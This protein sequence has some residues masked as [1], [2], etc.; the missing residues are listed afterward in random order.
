LPKI[1]NLGNHNLRPTT[2]CSD[3]S[4]VQADLRER[5]D[6]HCG[7]RELDPCQEVGRKKKW[8]QQANCDPM[9]SGSI[10]N[11]MT[12]PA[13]RKYIHR[14]TNALRGCDQGV[15]DLFKNVVVLDEDGK[16]WPVPIMWGTQEKAAAYVVQNQARKD[17]TLVVNRPILPL[18]AIHSTD[19]AY[20][21]DRY[22]Y[23]KAK[24]NFH[25]SSGKPLARQELL[26]RDT[27]FGVARGIP[28][29]VSYTLY[30][31]TMFVEDMNQIVE[32]I[33]LKFSPLAY[34]NVQG[35]PWEIGVRL[36]SIANNI[37]FEP[38]DQNQ[39]VLKYQFSLTAESYIPQPVERNKSVLKI[40]TDFF[41]SADETKMSDVYARQEIGTND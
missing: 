12:A 1:F 35:V 3:L 40:T 8:G 30:A 39:R 21:R 9:Q 41:N 16:A 7:E 18:M 4:A 11:D 36:D 28:V 34:I 23:H 2:E 24:M 29:D 22:I 31:W 32:Q 27:V 6:P 14:Y 19:L 13:N 17:N 20:N 37:D 38:G 10:I 15:T 26:E 33:I 5:N 25:D